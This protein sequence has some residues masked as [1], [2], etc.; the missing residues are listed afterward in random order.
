MYFY[1]FC[2]SNK[3]EQANLRRALLRSDIMR[4]GEAGDYSGALPQRNGAVSFIAHKGA[5]VVNCKERVIYV[6]A[7]GGQRGE[8]DYRFGGC[9]QL[10]NVMEKQYETR[11][12]SLFKPPPPI[13][14][15]Q[16]DYSGQTCADSI[17]RGLIR[18]IANWRQIDD[19]DRSH[20]HIEIECDLLTAEADIGDTC[21]KRWN[22]RFP[23][24]RSSL[25]EGECVNNNQ[26]LC[27]FD[28]STQQCVLDD[29]SPRTCQVS[30]SQQYTVLVYS[31]NFQYS[32]R[33]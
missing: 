31:I 21:D 20:G 12:A 15:D 11:R 29:A 23:T 32:S 2:Q 9:Q 16:P 28:N 1:C 6:S 8:Y 10:W 17:V 25:P 19:A 3:Y 18:D 27:R 30:L 26:A 7:S 14:S 13:V 22:G 4:V 33:I 24:C 5:C